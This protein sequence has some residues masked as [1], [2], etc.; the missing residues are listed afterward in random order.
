MDWAKTTARRDEKRLCLGLGASYIRELTVLFFALEVPA[1]YIQSWDLRMVTT[2]TADAVAPN[3]TKPST[4]TVQ[5]W[6]DGNWWSCVPIWTRW[7]SNIRQNI[8]LT[9]LPR[10]K[11]NFYDH[12]QEYFTWPQPITVPCFYNSFHS[13]DQVLVHICTGI[14]FDRLTFK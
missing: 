11:C 4:D 3:G 1:P 8:N 12:Y 14:P 10:V 6:L 5:C 2:E 7:C 13:E 9:A